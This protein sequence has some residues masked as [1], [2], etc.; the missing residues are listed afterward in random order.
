M[1]SVFARRLMVVIVVF[2]LL[3][4]CEP[5]EKAGEKIQNAAPA[6]E[7]SGQERKAGQEIQA[8]PVRAEPKTANEYSTLDDAFDVASRRIRLGN[9]GNTPRAP[10]FWPATGHRTSI[11]RCRP[12]IMV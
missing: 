7:V 9:C 3:L 2:G 8:T 4:A 1:V 6:V 5:E 11:F 12:R 10:G